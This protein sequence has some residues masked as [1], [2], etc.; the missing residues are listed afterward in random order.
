MVCLE[1]GGRK[2]ALLL[3]VMMMLFPFPLYSSVHPPAR[4]RS[5]NPSCGAPE[6]TSGIVPANLDRAPG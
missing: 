3:Q 1:E 2:A 4:R 6:C 5:T